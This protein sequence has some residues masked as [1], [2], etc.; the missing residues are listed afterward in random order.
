MVLVRERGVLRLRG[1]WGV[2][3]GNPCVVNA[4]KVDVAL[5]VCTLSFLWSWRELDAKELRRRPLPKDE[6]NSKFP[7]FET[8]PNKEYLFSLFLF[9]YLL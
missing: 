9:F 6:K 1:A 5:R 7:T 3:V 2:G 8:C 4:E